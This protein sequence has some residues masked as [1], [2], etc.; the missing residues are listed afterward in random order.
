MNTRLHVDRR[1]TGGAGLPLVCLHGWG[2]NL[3]VFD[4][5][6][7]AMPERESWAIDLPGHGRSEWR[8]ERAD[9]ASQGGDLLAALPA[10]CVLLGWSLGGQL[11]LELARVAPQR[12]H[13]LVLISATPR[14]AQ[15][16]DWPHGLDAD[17]VHN[18]S[19]SLG[20]DWRQTLSDFV[21]LQLRGGR[22]A[23]ATQQRVRIALD[24][25]G[26]PRP[27][28]LQAGMHLLGSLD[29]RAM[30][31]AVAQRALLIAGQN[32]RVVPPAATRWLAETLPRGSF[33]Q[34]P[35]AAHASFLSHVEECVA[36]LRPFLS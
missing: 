34:I 31:P 14:F 17:A 28:A 21:W 12:I 6:R 36:L 1:N 22:H 15:S 23:E 18:F 4:E 35:R 20:Q 3:C 27:E 29:L 16:P 32:D 10:Q 7:D 25:H 30:V 5:L 2:M 33:H 24:E 9:F 8:P 26:A 11:A 13:A 19:R